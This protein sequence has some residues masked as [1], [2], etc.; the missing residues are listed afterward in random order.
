MARRL[1][2]EHGLDLLIVDYLQLIKPR[3]SSDNVVQ[4]ITEI[5][6]G[7]KALARELKVPVLAVSQL[8]RNVEQRGATEPRLSDLRDSG[9]IEQDADVVMFISRM[10]DPNSLDGAN[11]ENMRKITIAKHRNGAIGSIE[12]GFDNERVSFKNL[13]KRHEEMPVL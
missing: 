12:L 7:L 11:N 1:Q 3:T 9:S 4:Q 10:G 6:R 13:D 8:S 5:S 2:V